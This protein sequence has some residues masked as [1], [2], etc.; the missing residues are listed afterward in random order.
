M[1]G[2]SSWILDLGASDHIFGN[3]SSFS[4]ISFPKISH[5]VTVANGS[6]VV[7]QGIA[8]VSLS[9]SLKLNSVFFFELQK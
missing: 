3:K 7:S 2:P 9:P 4:S 5:V 8:Q 1:K 6:K